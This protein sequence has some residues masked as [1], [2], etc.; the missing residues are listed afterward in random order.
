MLAFKGDYAD[1]IKVIPP[2]LHAR[3]R[4]EMA[5]D[6][7]S[8]GLYGNHDPH[9]LAN[10][11]DEK[12]HRDS[13]YVDLE[14]DRLREEAA[15]LSSKLGGECPNAI[16]IVGKVGSDMRRHR[17]TASQGVCSTPSPLCF[18]FHVDL[19][20]SWNSHRFAGFVFR[21]KEV[22]RRCPGIGEV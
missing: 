12:N 22:F 16:H 18:L 19:I 6:R 1:H 9:D 17:R 2:D 20:L 8:R 11:F 5:A 4:L 14:A 13:F 15:T 7:I 10:A 21:D 3:L